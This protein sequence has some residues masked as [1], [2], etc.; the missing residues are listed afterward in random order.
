MGRSL[1]DGAL[2]ILEDCPANCDRS[3]YRCLR[4]FGN[5]FEHELLDR[6]VGATLL[7]YLLFGD[8]P[9]LTPERVSQAEDRLFHDV[10]R[11]GMEGVRV[12][13]RA[14]F[15]VPGIGRIEAPILVRSGSR[16]LIVAIHGPLTPG[17]LGTSELRDAAEYGSTRV[18][19]IDELLVSRNLPQATLMVRNALN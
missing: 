1:Y 18:V 4:R 14:P 5:R 12:D 17:Y 3:C 7:R 13:R 15:D 10:L 16:E 19:P 8:D 9:G 11:L 6:H 2:R